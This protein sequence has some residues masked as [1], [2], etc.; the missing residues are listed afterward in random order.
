MKLS[1]PLIT[2]NWNNNSE[3]CPGQIAQFNY[4]YYQVFFNEKNNTINK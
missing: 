1:H 3:T 4:R 2:F